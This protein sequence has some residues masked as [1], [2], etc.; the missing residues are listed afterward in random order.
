MITDINLQWM[1]GPN[2]PKVAECRLRATYFAYARSYKIPVKFYRL[3]ENL[4]KI[5]GYQ[6]GRLWGLPW[7]PMT[8]NN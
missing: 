7:M 5:A 2:L 6:Y 1:D 3:I 8:T 4:N